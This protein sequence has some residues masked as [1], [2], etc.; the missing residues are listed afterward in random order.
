[1]RIR[2]P[3]G[4]ANLQN[5]EARHQP[6]HASRQQQG[7]GRNSVLHLSLEPFDF[8]E[9]DECGCRQENREADN[10]GKRMGQAFD[11]NIHVHTVETGNQRRHHQDDGETGHAFHDGVHVVG[12]NGREGIHRTRKDV[13]VDVHLVVSLFQFDE[14]VIGQFRVL[15]ILFIENV[16]QLAYHDLIATDGRVEVHQTLLQVHQPEQVLVTDAYSGGYPFSISGDIRSLP[17]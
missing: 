2:N 3:A 11:V 17:S 1:M 12:D 14:H 10:Q 8:P 4:D 7:I 9:N 13:T 15:V 16:L 5:I 6:H